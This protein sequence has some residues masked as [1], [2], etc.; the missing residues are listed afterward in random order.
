MTGNLLGDR[1][2]LVRRIGTGGMAEVW[3][4]V[5]R[6]LGRRVAVKLLHVHL[7]EDDSILA[8][9]RSE[10]QSAA[11]LTHPGIVA[12]YDT[13]TTPTTDAIVME[14]VEGR[15]LRS[16]LDE[17][18]TLATDDAIEVAIQVANA[19]GHAHDHGIVHRDI[20]PANVIVRPDRRIKL[21]DFGI[22]KALGD[23]TMTDSGS[24]IGTVRYLA[25]EQIQG[26]RVDGRTDLYALSTVLYE[27]LCGE[28]PFSAQDLVGAMDRLRRDA[29]RARRLRPDLDPELDDFLARGLAR[30]PAD[31]P[32]DAA[33]YAASLRALRRGDKT[34]VS[35]PVSASP[36]AATRPEP[37][38]DP[39]T[40]TPPESIPIRP[41]PQPPTA[42]HL[43]QR[44]RSVLQL[45]WP[46]IALIL[47]GAALVTVWLL[48]RPAGESVGERIQSS[49]SSEAPDTD[50]GSTTTE[51]TTTEPDS[52]VT[53]TTTT[54]TTTSTVPP[55]VGGV[56]A[57]A[58]DPLG[59]GDEHGDIAGR[60]LDDDPETFWYTERYVT[61]DLGGLKEGVGIVVEFEDPV[62]AEGLRI[63]ANNEGWAAR[64]YAG[65]ADAASLD[66]WG[67]PLGAF[68][69]LG[70]DATL[71]FDRT[72]T[73]AILVWITDLGDGDEP[74]RLELTEITLL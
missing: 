47:M 71:R 52:T 16:I 66:D 21:S 31:R 68:E 74:I 45:V 46:L 7:A 61:R 39:A 3:E 19:L 63:A 73:S 72:T 10:A 38:P 62:D 53:T 51:S 36:P 58:F 4:A 65:G 60:A 2:E 24:L 48:L 41:A 28:V 18:G 11:R 30:D 35:P 15:D 17:R 23:T 20:K 37:R 22:A 29:P 8:R 33:T 26:D 49:T 6:S 27:M 57:R 50:D 70:T 5:D 55:F 1:Y 43:R 56:R 67:A 69:S 59:D 44:K 54:T 14:L 32:P 42:K 34:V 9:F 12:I 64:V 40:P 13:V 25:P